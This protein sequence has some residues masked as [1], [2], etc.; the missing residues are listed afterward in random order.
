[1]L[2]VFVKLLV[3]VTWVHWQPPAPSGLL[4]YDAQT[5]PTYITDKTTITII[6]QQIP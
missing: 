1:M 5:M 4:G 3:S 2:S 6:Q